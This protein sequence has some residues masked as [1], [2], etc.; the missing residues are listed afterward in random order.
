M[1][2]FEKRGA[3]LE[4]LQLRNLEPTDSEIRNAV[5]LA[6]NGY[7]VNPM[8]GE[9][10]K[11]CANVWVLIVPDVLAS[12][13]FKDFRDFIR[14]QELIAGSGRMPDADGNLIISG[15]N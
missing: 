5:F 14:K 3:V 4:I 7:A 10:R 11:Q 13:S 6:D 2:E 12:F 15:L 8:T 9:W 1:N